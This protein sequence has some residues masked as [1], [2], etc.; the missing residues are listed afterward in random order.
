[1]T[2]QT[3]G[4][5]YCTAVAMAWTEIM[6]PPS[7]VT[8]STGRRGCA[9]L[10]P[11]A[12]GRGPAHAGKTAGTEKGLG[13]LR[14]VEMTHPHAVVTGVQ[15]DERLG[16]NGFLD[17]TDEARRQRGSGVA[18]ERWVLVVGARALDR[19]ETLAPGLGVEGVFAQGRLAGRDELSEDGLRIAD[20]RS[21]DGEGPSGVVGGQWSTWR[22]P[23]TGG[24][25]K[26][27]AARAR[28]LAG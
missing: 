15:G 28:C 21:L 9:T 22:D 23:L 20:E 4:S 12:A 8:P 1:M 7:P 24:G 6:K 14:L 3:T 25:R 19:G 26:R 5:A 2:S 11:S 16:I 13:L 18:V 17:E 27:R 10:S